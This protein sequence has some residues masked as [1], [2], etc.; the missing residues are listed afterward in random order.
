MITREKKWLIVFDSFHSFIDDD[1]D[2]R[3][4]EKENQTRLGDYYHHSMV[5][6]IIIIII[7]LITHP[8]IH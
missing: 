3:W 6:I 1:D 2:Y 8:Y 4:P 7:L 5:I